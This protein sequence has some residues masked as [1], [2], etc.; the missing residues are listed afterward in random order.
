MATIH[1]C[2]NG[3]NIL[4]TVPLKL[5][6]ELK[7]SLKHLTNSTITHRT[8][9]IIR[10]QTLARTVTV[11]HYSWIADRP[12]NYLSSTGDTLQLLLGG[13]EK[14]EKLGTY[15][16]IVNACLVHMFQKVPGRRHASLK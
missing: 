6:H 10:A 2:I 9:F 15:A 3:Y 1:N 5:L 16:S 13:F 11:P 7:R 14:K 8:V 12:Q 4:Q